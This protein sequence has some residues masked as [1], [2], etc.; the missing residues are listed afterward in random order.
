MT[1]LQTNIFLNGIH[2]LQITKE[3]R[4]SFPRASH[5]QGQLQ[6]PQSVSTTILLRSHHRP[7]CI[8]TILQ[9]LRLRNCGAIF[10]TDHNFFFPFSKTFRSFLVP[11]RPLYNGAF[12]WVATLSTHLHLVPRLG[13]SGATTL[14]HTP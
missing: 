10:D 8:M 4:S 2:P 9:A 7:V 3:G 12:I 14:L 13:I 1:A 11:N 5:F 6:T